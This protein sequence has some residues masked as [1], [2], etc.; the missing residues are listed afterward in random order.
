VCVCVCVAR[1]DVC[2]CV[3][4]AREDVCVCVCVCVRAWGWVGGWVWVGGW[5][6]CVCVL[7]WRVQARTG[8]DALCVPSEGHTP[9]TRT[10]AGASRPA[11]HL[12]APVARLL[13]AA[14]SR[15]ALHEEDLRLLPFV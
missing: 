6:G 4:V 11:A 13:G 2:V 15:V 7:A 1:E 9:Q 5:R 10:Q 8:D 12:R 3:C 14:A